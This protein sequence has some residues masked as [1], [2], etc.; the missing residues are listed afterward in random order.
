MT[1]V[2]PGIRF[3]GTCEKCGCQVEAMMKELLITAIH[4]KAE[5]FVTPQTKL[6]AHVM[7]P[8]CDG[9]KIEVNQIE[10]K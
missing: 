2:K 7:C 6:I 9:S 4:T 5:D 1:V 10:P 8:E 3:G